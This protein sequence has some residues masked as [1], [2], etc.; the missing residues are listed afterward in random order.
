MAEW[1]EVSLGSRRLWLVN[2]SIFKDFFT[3][4]LKLWN[5]IDE[6]SMDERWI[7]QREGLC[8]QSEPPLFCAFP[9]TVRAGCQRS[10][11]PSS[12]SIRWTRLP[13]DA[14]NCCNTTH[15]RVVREKTSGAVQKLPFTGS[16]KWVPT[17][18][19]NLWYHLLIRFNPANRLT[20]VKIHTNA[21]VDRW[22]TTAGHHNN[23]RLI[24]KRRMTT[25]N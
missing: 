14:N 16:S 6:G 24:T 5:G 10:L 17:D 2:L 20:S 7:K 13:R 1:P 12:Y 25:C 23:H 18:E 19:M 3:L 11:Q 21:F 4:K 22:T 8:K 15:G 9:H